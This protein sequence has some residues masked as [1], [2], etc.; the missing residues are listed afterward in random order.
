MKKLAMLA[1]VFAL[2]GAAYAADC[3]LG[4][5]PCCVAHKSCCLTK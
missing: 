4:H 5:G 2:A 1:F 3:C